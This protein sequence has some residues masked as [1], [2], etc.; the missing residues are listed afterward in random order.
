MSSEFQRMQRLAGINEVRIAHYKSYS[1][2]SKALGT[3]FH[4]NEDPDTLEDFEYE[5]DHENMVEFCRKIGYGDDAEDVAGE[6]TH[7]TSPGDEDE[8][9][10]FRQITNNPDLQVSD[11]TLGMFRTSIESEFEK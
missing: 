1:D 5:W 8:M 4:P 11:I 6:V 3:L 10:A 9:M 2:N 7:Y